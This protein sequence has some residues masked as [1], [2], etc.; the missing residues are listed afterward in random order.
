M[1]DIKGN[2][3]T[4]TDR[5]ASL[6]CGRGVCD[7]KW[8]VTGRPGTSATVIYRLTEWRGREKRL[9]EGRRAGNVGERGEPWGGERE[10]ELLLDLVTA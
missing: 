6:V 2:N 4:D 5:Y 10:G 3:S 7:S 9:W 8:Q 1:G